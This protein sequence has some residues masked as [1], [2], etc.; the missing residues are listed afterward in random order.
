MKLKIF[1]AGLLAG[2]LC[3][4]AVSAEPILINPYPDVMDA[5]VKAKSAPALVPPPV[6]EIQP[7]AQ[8]DIVEAEEIIK[9]FV[10]VDAPAPPSAS[11]QGVPAGYTV[12]QPGDAYFD[13]P[14]V[15][16]EK[17]DAYIPPPREAVIL[18]PITESA[19]EPLA[20][21]PAEPL[22]VRMSESFDDLIVNQPFEEPPAEAEVVSLPPPVVEPEPMPEPEPE[23]IAWFTSRQPP[24]TPMAAPQVEPV[25][26]ADEGLVRI[27]V[28]PDG[29]A[30]TDALLSETAPAG[31]QWRAL[32]GANIRQV[33]SEWSRLEG[34]KLVW[35]N[36]D[37]FAVLQSFE[38][39][40]PFHSAVKNLLDQY[41][42]DEVR[43]VATL[44]VDPQSGEKTLVVR[45]LNGA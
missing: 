26:D 12:P 5:P 40:G 29:T 20:A 31:Q 4:T 39:R 6:I 9:E 38:L 17:S 41:Q 23:K 21:E 2:C 36:E 15:V 43:P 13:P 25:E 37:A 32:E 34:A 45:V 42:G 28:N 22:R 8:A 35:D 3:S 7:D 30:R 44:H 19:P 14:S 16:A 10:E 18:P 24:R 11:V 27:A 1:C 33:L